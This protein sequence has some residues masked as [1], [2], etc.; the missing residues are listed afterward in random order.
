MRSLRSLGLLAAMLV[1]SAP[2]A[3]AASEPV[4]HESD[5]TPAAAPQALTSIE[6]V[7][8]FDSVALSVTLTDSVERIDG[9]IV[10]S[11]GLR[12][13]IVVGDR[14]ARL[15]RSPVRRHA[16][17]RTRYTLNRHGAVHG[18]SRPPERLSARNA[19]PRGNDVRS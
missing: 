4:P 6:I 15:E 10:A 14:I 19:S 7:N 17:V 2:P 3:L 1:L 16:A 8:R 9:V 13:Q 11:T 18:W 5:V 12:E